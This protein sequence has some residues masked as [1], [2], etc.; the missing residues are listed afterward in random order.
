MANVKIPLV[1]GAFQDSEGNPLANGY[2][3]MQLGGDAV[4]PTV[5]QLCAGTKVKV[6]LNSSGSATS[7]P[8]WP[9]NIMQPQNN[10]YTVIAYSAAGQ[11]V[12]GPQY[13]VVLNDQST[14]D[15]SRWVPANG[16]NMV[17]TLINAVSP[18]QVFQNILT[19]SPSMV[20]PAT[21][22]TYFVLTLT[23][24]ITSSTLTGT[25]V[26]GQLVVMQ[27]IQ[28]SVGGRTVTYPANFTGTTLQPDPTPNVKSLQIFI[29]D[30]TNI[31]P[32]STQVVD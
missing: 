30:G 31:I 3:I 11:R 13:Q 22:G 4:I 15:L 26:P 8:V 2:L 32:V 16:N 21:T 24:N 19:F 14:F 25:L 17:I 12:W 23:G 18:S 6:Q 5:G 27:F 9:T 29:Y 20:F 10:Y 7:T 1:G 28:D